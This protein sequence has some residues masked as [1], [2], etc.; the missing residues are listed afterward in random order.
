MVWHPDGSLLS[1]D[2]TTYLVQAGKLRGIPS[3]DVFYAYGFDFARVIN[4]G[5]AN[6]RHFRK[7]IFWA[8]PPGTL[9]MNDAGTIY[10]ITDQNYKRGVTSPSLF[11]DQGFRWS[12]IV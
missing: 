8:L 1:Y 11:D 9:L 4:I 12:D 2:G 5:S 7:E 3:P 6:F 10:E